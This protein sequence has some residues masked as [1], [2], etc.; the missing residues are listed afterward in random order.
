MGW[1]FCLSGTRTRGGSARAFML[2]VDTSSVAGIGMSGRSAPQMLFSGRSEG[3]GTCPKSQGGVAQIWI[4]T[5]LAGLGIGS[6]HRA[7]ARA[8]DRCPTARPPVRQPEHL[9]A[10]TARPPDRPA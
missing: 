7:T 5:G 10:R 2:F 8:P 1:T 9:T 3:S 6:V 4:T